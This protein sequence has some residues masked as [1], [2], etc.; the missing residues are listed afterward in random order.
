MKDELGTRIKE[1]YE[2]RSR[3][4]LPR[5]TYTIIRVDGK[6]FHTLTH[7]FNRPFDRDLME[8][9]D[10]TAIALCEEV[11]GTKMA[12]VQSDE[13]SLLVTDFEDIKTSAYFDGNIQKI[14]SITASI[15][16]AEFNSQFNKL[17]TAAAQSGNGAGV[18]KYLTGDYGQLKRALF[19]ARAFTIPDP[20]EVENYFVWR[21]KD[22]ERNSIQMVARAHFSHKECHKK[23]TSDLHEMLFAKGINWNDFTSGEK[24]GRI[25][26][27]QSYTTTI[28][29]PG[30][31]PVEVTRQRWVSYDGTG[32]DDRYETPIFAKDKNFLT[33]FIPIIDR[34]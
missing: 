1:Q 31:E 26:L 4:M 12:F 34:S 15:A 16:T 13:I 17:A 5:R 6:A 32:C 28:T 9:M 25:I 22:A 14:A 29:P 18:N 7:G 23:S 3:F 19:D 27:K 2:D 8:I 24:R 33:Q 11:Q 20:I 30:R 10:K 21:Q